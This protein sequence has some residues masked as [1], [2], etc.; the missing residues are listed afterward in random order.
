MSVGV[1]MYKIKYINNYYMNLNKN[2]KIILSF[3][4]F[5]LLVFF[6][7]RTNELFN[8]KTHDWNELFDGILF[9]NLNDRKDRLESVHNE[10]KKYNVNDKLINR[11]SAIK[12]SQCGHIGCAESHIKA[13][14]F[15]KEKKWNR[16]LILE[17]DFTFSMEKDKI[18]ESLRN[19]YKNN[20][21]WDV[22]LLGL[23][24]AN[25]KHK[26]DKTEIEGVV[27]LKHCTTAIGYVVNN[28][29]I[30]T[31]MNNFSDSLNLMKEELNIKLK[32]D[33]NHYMNFTNN[34]IDQRWNILIKKDNF[35]LFDPFILKTRLSKSSI[36][37][38]DIIYNKL[39]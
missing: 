4:F 7:S 34:A 6:L 29:Y 12:N 13:M 38:L 28:K 31:L 14:K 24:T 32:N 9:I 2:S 27:K 23:G 33:P 16:T 8:T 37:K 19:F 25:N 22:V 3:L 30:D 26:Y 20:N 18:F 15:A 39:K 11:I 1:I 21:N 17:D 36:D 35:Y 10:F 5:S